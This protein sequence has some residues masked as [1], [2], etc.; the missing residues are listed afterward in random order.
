MA[1]IIKVLNGSRISTGA[2]VDLWTSWIVHLWL[3]HRGLLLRHVVIGKIVDFRC[4][5]IE[6][7]H[8]QTN[9]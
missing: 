7:E 4:G 5:A 2:H 3:V 1:L 9:V 8:N 6:I